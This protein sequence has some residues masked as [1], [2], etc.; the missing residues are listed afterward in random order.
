M[1]TR[2]ERTSHRAHQPIA[3][4]RRMA[5]TDALFWFAQSALPEFRP[6]IAGLYVLDR[7]PDAAAARASIEAAL[8]EYKTFAASL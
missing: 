7:T 4:P 5:P 8:D 2:A 6:I 1:T 3:V